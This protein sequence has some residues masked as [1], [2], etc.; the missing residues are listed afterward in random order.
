MQDK[1]EYLDILFA[2]MSALE[3]THNGCTEGEGGARFK[4]PALAPQHAL[5]YLQLHNEAAHGRQV[6]G[7]GGG[8]NKARLAKMP[9]TKFQSSDGDIFHVDVDNAKQSVTVKT[10][11]EE[12]DKEVVP[13][14]TKT[15]VI[16]KSQNV[17]VFAVPAWTGRT[18][19]LDEIH[20]PVLTAGCS[21]DSF[22]SFKR[23]WKMYV[24]T[25]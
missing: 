23:R 10:M 24:R 16:Q 7:A 20:R 4:T 6:V 22:M 3:C 21:E 15:A 2:E 18:S 12:E 17:P 8:A 25:H 13:L 19:R 9:S 1:S 14:P 11:M 5:E